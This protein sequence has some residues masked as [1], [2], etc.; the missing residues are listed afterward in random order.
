MER[1]C[2][3]LQ[4]PKFNQEGIFEVVIQREKY[5]VLLGNYFRI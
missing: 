1:A 4:E 3:Q 2:L 5:S